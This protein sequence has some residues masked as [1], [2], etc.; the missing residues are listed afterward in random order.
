MLLLMG[1]KD[2]DNDNVSKYV[3]VLG[4]IGGE[5]RWH[6][7]NM[8]SLGRGILSNLVRCRC[9]PHKRSNNPAWAET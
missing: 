1:W 6:S 9:Q 4:I 8:S 5:C 7:S 2:N 3:Q